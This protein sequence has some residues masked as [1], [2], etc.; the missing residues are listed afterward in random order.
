[1]FFYDDDKKTTGAGR[2]LRTPAAHVDDHGG[3]ASPA[4][5]ERDTARQASNAD[6][7]TE[8]ITSI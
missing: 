8:T 3:K 6:N 2:L 7:I 1:M 4:E 5:T